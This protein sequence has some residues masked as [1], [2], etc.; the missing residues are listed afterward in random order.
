MKRPTPDA[1][2][3]KKRRLRVKRKDSRK[4]A[5]MRVKNPRRFMRRVGFIAGA[6]VL[7]IFLLGP[8]ARMTYAAISLEHEAR[9]LHQSGH[10]L[11]GLVKTLPRIET[12][13]RTLDQSFA[14][15]GYVGL[16]PGIGGM[17]RT[18]LAVAKARL[19]ACRSGL[20]AVKAGPRLGK[21]WAMV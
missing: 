17:Y 4:K 13:V 14:R 3:N 18:L 21:F 8:V 2:S 12:S 19:A 10:R 5:T 15:L 20:S 7:W 6:G 16:V 11:K 1:P 9:S